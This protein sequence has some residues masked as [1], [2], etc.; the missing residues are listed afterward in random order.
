MSGE[1]TAALTA[2]RSSNIVSTQTDRGWIQTGTRRNGSATDLLVLLLRETIVPVV[3]G[4]SRRRAVG[5]IHCDK[6]LQLV[7]CYTAADCARSVGNKS[8]SPRW[9]VC[10]RVPCAVRAHR[11]PVTAPYFVFT[12]AYIISGGVPCGGHQPYRCC[13]LLLLCGSQVEAV[14]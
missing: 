14:A 6:F 9:P 8:L 3:R 7:R 12:F 2:T 11:W 10:R 13:C 4:R 5:W 1:R